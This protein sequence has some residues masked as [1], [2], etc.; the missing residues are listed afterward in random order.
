MLEIAALRWGA[1][2]V[3]YAGNMNKFSRFPQGPATEIE[4]QIGT[5]VTFWSIGDLSWRHTASDRRRVAGQRS[6]LPDKEKAPMVEVLIAISSV[7]FVL[8]PGIVAA[9]VDLDSVPE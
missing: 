9:F 5:P 8:G 1:R 6:M 4:P 2:D 3:V 7:L